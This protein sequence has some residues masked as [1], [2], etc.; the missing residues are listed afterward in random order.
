M[1]S[2]IIVNNKTGKAVFETFSKDTATKISAGSKTHTV[3][4]ILEYLVNLN[5]L[6]REGS[7]GEINLKTI[8]GLRLKGIIV[9]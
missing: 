4:P 6:I 9:K 2:W 5:R 7:T 3:V 8:F 1:S